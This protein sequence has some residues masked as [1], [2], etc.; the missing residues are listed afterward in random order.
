MNPF[1]PPQMAQEEEGGDEW[2]TSFSDVITLI[3][4]FFVVL[5]AIFAI[6]E[7][8]TFAAAIYSLRGLGRTGT[9][10]PAL[11][12]K[13]EAIQGV[14]QS[15]DNRVKSDQYKGNVKFTK[16][17]NGIEIEIN[18][19]KGKA[20]FP[21]GSANLTRSAQRLI[22]DVVKQILDPPPNLE[23]S[24]EQFRATILQAISYIE[25]QGHS[26]T[27]PT[28]AGSKYPSNWE[29]SLARANN[30]RRFLEHIGF[31]EELLR[32]VRVT[33]YA[34]NKPAVFPEFV[35]NDPE[36]TRA[37]R[38]RNRRVVLFFSTMKG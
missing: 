1:G 13:K 29:L 25:I 31:P 10:N 23:S 34:H 8:E 3:L 21:P 4:C 30:V 22:F 12:R 9:Y 18:E 17:L 35:P 6:K 5:A 16:Y 27:L 15:L 26:D 2:L 37:N 28:G 24:P 7:R 32:K 33:G 20:I 14:A 19:N 38:N 11:V 36:Q